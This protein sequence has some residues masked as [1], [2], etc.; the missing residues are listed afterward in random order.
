MTTA[1]LTTSYQEPSAAQPTSQN[2][3]AKETVKTVNSKKVTKVGEKPVENRFVANPFVGNQDMGARAKRSPGLGYQIS[4]TGS[5]TTVMPESSVL[6][7]PGM[8]SLVDDTFYGAVFPRSPVAV[9]R[10]E[11]IFMKREDGGVR[12]SNA[13]SL[14]PFDY[15]LGLRI[16]AE[17]V[18]GVEG[19]S[20]TYTGI[21]EWNGFARVN[22]PGA[23]LGIRTTAPS[24]APG[25]LAPFNGANFQ[26]QYHN[27][28]LHSLEWNNVT[29][30]WDVLNLFWGMRVT[31]YEEEF[32]FFSSRPDGQQGLLSMDFEN[33][34]IGPQI[35]G[36]VFYDIGAR[37][38]TGIKAKLGV[39][40]NFLDRETLLITNGVRRINNQDSD[41]EWNFLAEFGV[42]GR[43]RLGPRAFLRGGYE[44][45]YNSSMFGVQDNL[46]SV[47]NSGFG[48][49]S[50]DES[51][52]IHGANRGAG[53][54]VVNL[55]FQC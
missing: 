55:E 22:S 43:M 47:I 5:Q 16:H 32:D 10:G 12:L 54:P 41:T 21:Q 51:M 11:S 2:P 36:E 7:S 13:F 18:F 3:A 31:H 33:L 50:V 24:L 49:T 53:N 38:S 45:W 34:H 1:A 25:T 6:S 14:D 20:L 4:S 46:P 39:T 42:F 26:Q 29:W 19:R 37:F 28:N 48:T 35:G 9:L 40:A 52:L 30:G 23:S 8:D 27:G 17:R 15:D 44:M